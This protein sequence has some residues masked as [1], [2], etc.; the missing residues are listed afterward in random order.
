MAAFRHP[1][2]FDPAVRVA[3]ALEKGGRYLASDKLFTIQLR[4]LIVTSFPWYVK[5]Y[6]LF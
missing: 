3:L 6:V 1:S 5:K 2:A 4:R